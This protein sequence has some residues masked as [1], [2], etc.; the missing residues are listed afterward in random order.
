M[1]DNSY[2]EIFVNG[3]SGYT[4]FSVREK[5]LSAEREVIMEICDFDEGCSDSINLLEGKIREV[6]ILQT[7]DGGYLIAYITG[8]DEE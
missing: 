5:G 2:P 8:G 7:S 6:K 3:D 4:L 1:T